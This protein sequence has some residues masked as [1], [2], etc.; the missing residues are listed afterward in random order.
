[1]AALDMQLK[2]QFHMLNHRDTVT[3]DTF[4]D[5]WEEKTDYV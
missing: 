4:P 1:V 2:H 5:S 3:Y